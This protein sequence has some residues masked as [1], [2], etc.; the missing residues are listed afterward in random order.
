MIGGWL[1]LMPMGKRS[2]GFQQSRR[3][4]VSEYM[5]RFPSQEF[6]WCVMGT[7]FFGLIFAGLLAINYSK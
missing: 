2:K 1:Y 5:G 4:G 3:E 7:A 6:I